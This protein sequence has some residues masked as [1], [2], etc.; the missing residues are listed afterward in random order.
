MVLVFI[1]TI[2][3]SWVPALRTER[4]QNGWNL[5]RYFPMPSSGGG[6]LHP[7]ARKFCYSKFILFWQWNIV[8]Q[9][10]KSPSAVLFKKKVCA[11][12]WEGGVFL[13]PTQL[14]DLLA[15]SIE[16]HP[17]PMNFWIFEIRNT[18]VIASFIHFTTISWNH[19]SSNQKSEWM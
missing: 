7:Q 12:C 15:F 2:D 10:A 4:S 1:K 8:C 9:I 16:R 11:F 13:F 19:L 6:A 3:V 14:I 17:Y 18:Q 5:R